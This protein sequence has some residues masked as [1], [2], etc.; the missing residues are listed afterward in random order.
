MITPVSTIAIISL[1]WGLSSWRMQRY[2]YVFTNIISVLTILFALFVSFGLAE[3]KAEH[4]ALLPILSLEVFASYFLIKRNQ[5]VSLLPY[6]SI[7][8]VQIVY[9]TVCLSF[10]DKTY[11]VLFFLGAMLLDFIIGA[12]EKRTKESIGKSFITLALI[13]SLVFL[14]RLDPSRLSFYLVT[15]VYW[16]SRRLFPM[17][18]SKG[19]SEAG[20]YSLTSRVALIVLATSQFSF[21]LSAWFSFL[22]VFIVAGFTLITFFLLE[23]P[24]KSW[25]LIK[26]SNELI[27]LVVTFISFGKLEI[28]SLKLI[29]FF[30][31]FYY[32]PMVLSNFENLTPFK[33]GISFFI[34][35]F[36][37]GIFLGPIADF[38]KSL[39]HQ[40]E[41][42]ALGI[43]LL[44][45]MGSYWL[46][47]LCFL[48]KFP[49]LQIKDRKIDHFHPLFLASVIITSVVISF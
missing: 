42:G 16:I 6:Y 18:L 25:S 31:L 26:G 12:S 21:P 19:P 33:R 30:N 36:I 24:Y 15:F 17:G 13:L 39:L 20:T 10:P 49:N 5:R 14:T 8:L 4:M 40:S 32:F 48:I 28:S 1:L 9:L 34:F 11:H 29:L 2:G 37:N 45:L 43:E 23:N 7:P 22:L 35:F 3:I 47:N 27:L 46:L 41:F 38:T 44:Y